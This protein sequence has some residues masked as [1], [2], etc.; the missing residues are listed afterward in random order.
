MCDADSP[1][2]DKVCHHTKHTTASLENTCTEFDNRLLFNA[3]PLSVSL[4]ELLDDDGPSLL[5]NQPAKAGPKAKA[6]P[7]SKVASKARH[8]ADALEDHRQTFADSSNMSSHV[9]VIWE[10]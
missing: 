9:L 10:K 8:A 1:N 4:K 7:K 2:L 6:D 5:V 3:D